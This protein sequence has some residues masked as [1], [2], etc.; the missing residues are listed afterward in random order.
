[1]Y[2]LVQ[3]HA[4]LV[5]PLL[6]QNLDHEDSQVRYWAL[7]ALP[8]GSA[9]ASPKIRRLLNDPSPEVRR[10]ATNMLEHAAPPTKQ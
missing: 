2:R 10:L 9:L 1:M 3:E 4:A 8:S 7:E 5:V 6:L